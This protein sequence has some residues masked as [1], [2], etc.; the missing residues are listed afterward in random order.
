MAAPATCVI[1]APANN[2]TVNAGP[3]GTA[4][5]T[6]TVTT[7]A[8]TPVQLK[9][10]AVAHGSPVTSNGSGLATFTNVVFPIGTTVL[11]AVAGTDPDTTTSTAKNVIVVN[12]LAAIVQ[13][14]DRTV[15]WY[16]NY[17]AGQSVAGEPPLTAR[18]AACAW[19]AVSVVDY[20]LIGAFN[21][22]AGNTDRTRWQSVNA[23]ANRL[24]YGLTGPWLPK[25]TDVVWLSTPN[26]LLVIALDLLP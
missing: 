17:L 9:F 14:S 16:L 23:C 13:G 25:D 19:A 1:T 24:A 15:K 18:A 8:A 22:K 10:G 6:V 3:D 21:V 4:L 2:Y 11:T 12:A 7:D 26:A 20:D 5:V